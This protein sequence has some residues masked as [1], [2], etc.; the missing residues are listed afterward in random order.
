MEFS[1]CAPSSLWFWVWSI[2]QCCGKP[3]LRQELCLPLLLT[4]PIMSSYSHRTE[5]P[6]APL[7]CS[8]KSQPVPGAAECSA[9]AAAELSF[10]I[11]VHAE[12]RSSCRCCLHS[13][14]R[15]LTFSARLR[16]SGG[17]CTCRNMDSDKRVCTQE[18]MH[19]ILGNCLSIHEKQW[20]HIS[21]IHVSSEIVLV[22]YDIILILRE[23]FSSSGK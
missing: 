3:L 8:S 17:D 10:L 7:L 18:H 6:E 14:Y 23:S 22:M 9:A 15:L 5:N 21:C 1:P 4:L 12:S 11:T 13:V 20:A 16:G 2:L 19:S